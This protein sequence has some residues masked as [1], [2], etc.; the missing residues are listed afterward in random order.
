MITF[1]PTTRIPRPRQSLSNASNT[2]R[3]CSFPSAAKRLLEAREP[4]K[5][6]LRDKEGLEDLFRKTVSGLPDQV[7][8]ALRKH[9]L[10]GPRRISIGGSLL[11]GEPKDVL[12]MNDGF[13]FDFQPEVVAFAPEKILKTLI[14]HE[15]VHAYF[16]SRGMGFKNEPAEHVEVRKVMRK[17]SFRDQDINEWGW[18]FLG[19]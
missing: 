18:R 17:W 3:S 15:L 13:L 5:A 7:K 4:E 10:L 16:R 1:S 8:E 12:A 6:P 9:W 2:T 14:V 11:R 19:I